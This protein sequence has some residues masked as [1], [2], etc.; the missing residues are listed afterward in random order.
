[1]IFWLKYPSQINEQIHTTIYIKRGFPPPKNSKLNFC[2]I[3]RLNFPTNF[4]PVSK[5]DRVMLGQDNSHIFLLLSANTLLA[6]KDIVMAFINICNWSRT[7]SGKLKTGAS[8]RY[9]IIFFSLLNQSKAIR[10]EES[11]EY[12]TSLQPLK[13]RLVSLVGKATVCWAGGRRLKPRPN[14]NSGS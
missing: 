4:N 14:P 7:L 8:R 1:M 12:A 13:R 5:L 2:V 10:A 9:I 6:V 11:L 3:R